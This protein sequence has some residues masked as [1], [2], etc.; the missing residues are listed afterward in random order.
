MDCVETREVS[1]PIEI[2]HPP[3][4]GHDRCETTPIPTHEDPT[5]HMVTHPSSCESTLMPIPDEPVLSQLTSTANT[6]TRP[7]EMSKRFGSSRRS[8]VRKKTTCLKSKSPSDITNSLFCRMSGSK[9]RASCSSENIWFPNRKRLY[10]P[11]P[12]VLVCNLL[13]D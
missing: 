6:N 5:I 2:S 9:R 11:T 4:E 13:Y 3:F 12:N 8:I 10:G 7:S 1:T